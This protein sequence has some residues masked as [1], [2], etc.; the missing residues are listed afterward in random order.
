M[1]LTRSL[2]TTILAAALCAAL[3]PAQQESEKTHDFALHMEKAQTALRARHPELA[4]PELEAAIAVNPSSLEAQANLG[5]LLFFAGKPADAIPHLRAAIQ[6]QPN[7]AKIQGVLGLAELHTG[8][9]ANGRKDLE[10]AFPKIE[11]PKFQIQVGLELVSLYTETGDMDAAP[12]ILTQLHKAAP[13]DPEVLYATYRAYADLSGAAM[14]TLSVAAPSSAQM[15]QA[16]AHEAMRQGNPN[17]AIVHF[18][19]AIEIDPTLPGAH[20]ELA[21]V[22]RTSPDEAVKKQAEDEY[23]KALAQNPQDEKAL[24]RLGD[25]EVEHGQMEQALQAYGKAADL[26]PGDSEPKL[27]EAK[28]LIEQGQTQ[29]ALPLLQSAVQADPSNAVAHYRLGTL[30]QKMGRTEDAKREI[31]AYKNLKDAKQKMRGVYKDLLVQPQQI[32]AD[33]LDEK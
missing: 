7:L 17:T 13:M 2:V 10:A 25:I 24:V 28:I 9:V 11:E 20:F 6:L 31:E 32:K 15:Q 18:R 3:C 33:A 8:D 19:K 12:A 14:L 23:R 5:V 26:Q 16:L 27:G 29:K 1:I 21:E 4:I 30:Y 22:L